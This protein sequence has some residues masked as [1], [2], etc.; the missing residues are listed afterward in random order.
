MRGEKNIYFE[1]QNREV[2]QLP[3]TEIYRY[4]ESELSSDDYEGEAKERIERMK[5][6]AELSRFRYRS[7]DHWVEGYSLYPRDIE[8]APVIIHNR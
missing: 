4:K 2:I 3:T 7:N 5:E 8:N 1:N 6:I